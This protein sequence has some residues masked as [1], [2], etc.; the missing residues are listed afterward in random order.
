MLNCHIFVARLFR[1]LRSLLGEQGR[2]V[3]H[4]WGDLKMSDNEQHRR[5]DRREPAFRVDEQ[6]QRREAPRPLDRALDDHEG[7]RLRPAPR[8]SGN[9]TS[10]PAAQRLATPQ[11]QSAK[12]ARADDVSFS[13]RFR[14]PA[15]EYQRRAPLPT[16]PV[17][18]S[19]MSGPWLVGL[20]MA[21]L[22]ILFL[23]WGPQ[24]G[25]TLS[26]WASKAGLTTAA[27]EIAI[28]GPA[29]PRTSG[30]RSVLGQPS[31]SAAQI[32][33]VLSQYGSPASGTGELFYAKGVEYGID[34]AY[35]LAF[36]IHESSAGTAGQ[37]AGLKPDGSTTHNVGNIICAGYPTCYGR[38]RDYPSWEDGIGDWYRLIA[39]EYIGGRGLRTVDE[40]L[41]IYAPSSDNNDPEGYANTV[42]R[43]VDEWRQAE[44]TR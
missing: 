4:D 28:S 32:D 39:N 17:P 23:A 13:Q 35:A 3:L 10:R 38:F 26:R 5:S 31:I 12:Q 20:V 11:A 18:L 8:Q 16:S 15:A 29:V 34:P 44:G 42:Q 9:P 2:L 14:D 40:I 25:A 21:S 1:I 24:T 36:F 6:P 43:M 37:W 22:L 19:G 7:V 27:V 41:P 33:A 30:D